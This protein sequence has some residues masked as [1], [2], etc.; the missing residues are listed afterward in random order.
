MAA[1]GIVRVRQLDR[2]VTFRV[3]GWTT[4]N[5]SLMFRKT[6]EQHLAAG[7]TVLRVDLGRCTFMDSTFVGTLL[8]LKRTVHSHKLGEFSLIGPSPECCQLFRKMGLEGAFPLV[9]EQLDE[10][11][12]RE[13]TRE[14]EDVSAFKCNVVQAHRELACLDGPAGEQFRA[15]VR[16]LEHD[17]ETEKAK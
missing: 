3:E 4:M 16:C 5:Q 17:L 2:T 9:E 11:G 7:A 15:V 14:G 13:L 6:A 12:W 8:F 10:Q 1:Q